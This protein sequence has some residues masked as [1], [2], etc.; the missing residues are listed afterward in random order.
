MKKKR[1]WTGEEE[2]WEEVETLQT[3][4]EDWA[5]EIVMTCVA[6]HLL[7]CPRH[8]ALQKAPREQRERRGEGLTFDRPFGF[9][10]SVFSFGLFSF[11]VVFD[12]TGSKY[13]GTALMRFKSKDWRM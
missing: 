11:L 8:L 2:R 7:S 4:N 10:A 5:S 3:D 9:F 1:E 13:A 12:E 6:N